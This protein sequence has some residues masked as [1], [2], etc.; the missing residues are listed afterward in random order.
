MRADIAALGPT[1]A[2]NADV[3]QYLPTVQLAYTQMDNA[4]HLLHVSFMH[5][6]G[7]LCVA[8]RD[9]LA[10]LSDACGF[11]QSRSLLPLWF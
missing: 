8:G 10:R 2:K 1:N 6:K 5:G 7:D 3:V 9:R 4:I 11:R